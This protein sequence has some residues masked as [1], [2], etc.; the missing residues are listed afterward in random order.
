MNTH[1]KEPP[2][3]H[4]PNRMEKMQAFFDKLEVKMNLGRKDFQDL[5]MHEMKEFRTFFN[6]EKSKVMESRKEVRDMWDRMS[7]QFTSLDESMDKV[8][9]DMENVWQ[10]QQPEIKQR[11]QD[12]LH[13]VKETRDDFGDVLSGMIE[14]FRQVPKK[15][16]KVQ[17]F[18]DEKA[19]ASTD[20]MDILKKRILDF[21]HDLKERI[22]DDQKVD[23]F[24]K[25]VGESFDR[26]K[27]ALNDLFS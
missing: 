16:P 22:P 19:S 5:W 3:T 18:M 7:H 17:E 1:T 10:K 15:D 2:V 6:E 12:L 8:E 21:Q 26:M 14:R 25:E 11:I 23:Q 9:Q 20:R 24:K 4:Q 13:E 27:K